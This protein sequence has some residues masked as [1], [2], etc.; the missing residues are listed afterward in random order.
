MTAEHVLTITLKVSGNPQDEDPLT[1]AEDLL[2]HA[3]D[4]GQRYT[5]AR[6]VEIVWASWVAHA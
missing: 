5:D 2:E 1:V 6:K 4:Q 3:V